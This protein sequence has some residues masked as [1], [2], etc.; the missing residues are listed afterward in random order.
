MDGHAHSHAGDTALGGLGNM[1]GMG[2]MDMH[3]VP[4]EWTEGGVDK[5]QPWLL[6]VRPD[7]LSGW[8]V[9]IDFM[10][11]A[12]M[13]FAPL[14]ASLQHSPGVRDNFRYLYFKPKLFLY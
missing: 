14:S 12:G 5:L 9:K 10:D 6:A 13:D 8:N 7:A 3:T 1:G 2:G 11:Q 4:R